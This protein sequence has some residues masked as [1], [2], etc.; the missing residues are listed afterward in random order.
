MFSKILIVCVF[1]VTVN[2]CSGAHK[3]FN[4]VAHV[5]SKAFD[6]IIPRFKRALVK[7]DLVHSV[8]QTQKA[9][10][11]V[12]DWSID[13]DDTIVIEV[14]VEYK[15]INNDLM[16]RFELRKRELPQYMLFVRGRDKP[17]YYLGDILRSSDIISFITAKSKVWFD[18]PMYMATFDNFVEEFFEANPKDMKNVIG[19]AEKA[20]VGLDDEVMRSRALIYIE[21][22]LKVVDHGEKK[23]DEDHKKVHQDLDTGAYEDFLEKQRMEANSRIMDVFVNRLKAVKLKKRAE[24][25]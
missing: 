2:I 5:N 23:L 13:D 11:E 18:Y 19:R 24:E 20:A 14:C 22:M 17:L 3:H 4:G 12:A 21:T 8:G 15:G 6:K 16:E 1:L 9:F 10:K 7:F 25:L